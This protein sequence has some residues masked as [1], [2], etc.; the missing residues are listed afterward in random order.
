MQVVVVITATIAIVITNSVGVVNLVTI[1]KEQMVLAKLN[2]VKLGAEIIGIT[3]CLAIPRLKAVPIIK[4]KAIQVEEVFTEQADPIIK[5]R[6][7]QVEEV[8]TVTE[9]AD[10]IIEV[11]T[12]RAIPTNLKADSTVKVKAIQVKLQV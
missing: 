1:V 10:P 7:V 9:Q 5:V 8:F 3:A 12:Q 4:V 6:A 11:K 2:L